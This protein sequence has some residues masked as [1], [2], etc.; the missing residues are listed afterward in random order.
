MPLIHVLCSRLIAQREATARERDAA[1]AAL[2]AMTER[3]ER[4]REQVVWGFYEMVVPEYTQGKA[5][6]HEICEVMTAEEANSIV[7]RAV[8][9]EKE[10]DAHA[11][12]GKVLAGLLAGIRERYRD[13]DGPTWDR[14]DAALSEGES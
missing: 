2:A 8:R 12:R 13:D 11:E 9:L 6:E 4:F 5:G 3:A 10:R 7:Q 14:I 1:R